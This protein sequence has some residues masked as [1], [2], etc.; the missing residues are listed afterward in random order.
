MKISLRELFK[1][2]CFFAKLAGETLL[3][4]FGE[5]TD[6]LVTA[7]HVPADKA[8]SVVK[9]LDSQ[10]R[11]FSMGLGRGV[12]LHCVAVRGLHQAVASCGIHE[13]GLPVS[14]VDHRPVRTFLII[15]VPEH[16][17][18]EHLKISAEMRRFFNCESVKSR[19]AKVRNRKELLQLIKN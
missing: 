19:L 11:E 8:L 13:R 10:W 14:D 3:E 6:F 9:A 16:L 2:K 7:G 17:Y 4:I 15:L 5:M 1:G 12:A 18:V